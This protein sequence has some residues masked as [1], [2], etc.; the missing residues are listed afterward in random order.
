MIVD[1]AHGALGRKLSSVIQLSNSEIDC[2]EAMQKKE[3]Q[4]A[5]GRELVRDGEPYDQT[6][7]LK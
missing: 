1:T 6:K 3:R 4:V 7:V 5:A 2:I